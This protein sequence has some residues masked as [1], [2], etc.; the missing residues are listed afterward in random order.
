MSNPTQRALQVCANWLA[1]C[2]KLGWKASDVPR[3][4]Q[5]WLEYHD[6][7]GNLKPQDGGGANGI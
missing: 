1:Y 4:E 7:Y 3:L 5:L 2:L 6:E